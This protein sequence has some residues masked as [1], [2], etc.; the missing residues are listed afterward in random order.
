MLQHA[1][2]S[3][4]TNLWSHPHG[5]GEGEPSQK[6]II[7]HLAGLAFNPHPR[8]LL[9]DPGCGLIQKTLSL[10]GNAQIDCMH[11]WF[12]D[13]TLS[14]KNSQGLWSDRAFHWIELEKFVLTQPKDTSVV[15]KINKSADLN[16]AVLQV[17]A[18]AEV[19]RVL[20]WGGNQEGM[21]SLP[22]KAIS[23]GYKSDTLELKKSCRVVALTLM[24]LTQDQSQDKG[25]RQEHHP[26][27]YFSQVKYPGFDLQSTLGMYGHQKVDQGTLLL[28]MELDVL[29]KDKPLDSKI[30]DFGAGSG[31]LGLQAQKLG[32]S[33]VNYSDAHSL[34][35]Q[36]LALNLSRQEGPAVYWD[37]MLSTEMNK[38]NIIITNPP[39]H[40]GSKSDYHLG[41]LWIEALF[42]VLS[43]Q[44]EVILVANEFLKFDEM[45]KP[46]FRKVKK[47]TK[48]SGYC[49]WNLIL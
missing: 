12:Q 33:Q 37:Y 10:N 27:E 14:Q 21:K 44:G 29:L 35:C 40:V 45:A 2:Q 25:V 39:F 30:M 49:V 23:F 19:K 9:I 3:E 1:F 8:W 4:T 22:K 11:Q 5:T 47:L 43:P 7:R 46:Y 36:S 24:E 17:L 16:R 41:E 48:S 18:K 42:R 28:L 26:M 32:F 38:Y 34:A 13:F 15:F 31:V 20:V 6:L